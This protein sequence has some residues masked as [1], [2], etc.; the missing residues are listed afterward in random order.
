MLGALP[1]VPLRGAQ[2]AFARNVLNQ[3]VILTSDPVT[4]FTAPLRKHREHHVSPAPSCLPIEERLTNLEATLTYHLSLTPVRLLGVHSI[5]SSAASS[6]PEMVTP[7]AFA[8]LRL[9]TNSNL[10]GRSI[11]KS[12]G[13]APLRILET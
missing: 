11:G 13:R 8:A 9:I 12:E 3:F 5:T 4:D 2:F 7:N 1:W 10:V 6:R